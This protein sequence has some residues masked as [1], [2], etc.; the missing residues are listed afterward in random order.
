MNEIEAWRLGGWLASKGENVITLLAQ[1]E[2]VHRSY[3][4]AA[5]MQIHDQIGR[6]T[7]K[8]WVRQGWIDAM[9]ERQE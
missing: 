6:E 4:N 9:R 2:A 1:P 7:W 5:A 3:F 8:Y